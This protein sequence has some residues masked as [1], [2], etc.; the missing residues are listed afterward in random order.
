MDEVKAE[1]YMRRAI[2]LALK[3]TGYTD[4]NPLVGAVIVKD[5]KIIGEGYHERYGELHAE[6]NALLHCTEDPKGAT[7]YVTLE[8]CCHHGKQPPC[9]EALIEAGISEVVVGS[10]D[11]NPL[12]AGKGIDQLRAAGIDVTTDFM[13]DECDAINN[14]FF[15]YITKKLPYVTLKYAMTLDGKIASATG[16]SKW[17]SCER[18]R[19]Y[20]HELRARNMAIMAGIGT[21][22]A[23][24]PMLN[25]R[26]ADGLSPIRVICDTDLRTPLDSKVVETARMTESYR[27][28]ATIIATSVTD[29]SRLCAYRDKGVCIINVPRAGNGHLDMRALMAKLGEMKIDS[30]LVEG[31]ASINWA[32]LES[33]LANHACCFIAPMIMGGEGAKSPVSGVGADSPAEAFRLKNGRVRRIG[34]DIFV[35]GDL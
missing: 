33:G 30:V 1:M 24:D 12:V 15:Y 27:S 9:T 6:R 22:L 11:P 10:S 14:V 18:S 23:D 35:E 26:D 32:V 25:V 20:V 3:G 4:P 34:N 2:E 28:P 31:G 13:K 29:E 19:R 8:P 5:G 7:I 21:V 17:I 16:K